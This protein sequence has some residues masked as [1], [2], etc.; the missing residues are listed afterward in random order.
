LKEQNVKLK[1]ENIKIKEEN[2]NINRLE[3]ESLELK[4]EVKEFKEKNEF[5]TNK[6]FE[7]N[8]EVKKVLVDSNIDIKEAKSELKQIFDKQVNY[9]QSVSKSSEEITK[10]TIGLLGFLQKQCPNAKPLL[11]FT[12]DNYDYEFEMNKEYIESMLYSHRNGNIGEFLGKIINNIFLKEKKED[13]SLFATDVVRYNYSI[14]EYIN[15]TKNKWIVDKGASKVVNLIIN[16]LL[17][18]IV[19]EL[20]IHL[21]KEND[22]ILK[23]GNLKS[24]DYT[25]SDEDVKLIEYKETYESNYESDNSDSSSVYRTPKNKKTSFVDYKNNLFKS[26][27]EYSDEENQDSCSEED[28]MI[29]SAAIKKQ[30]SKMNSNKN[31]KRKKYNK[32]HKDLTIKERETIIKTSTKIIEMIKD[33]ENGIITKDILK[34]ITKYYHLDKSYFD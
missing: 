26:K 9:A 11:E 20:K 30:L 25:S 7:T 23:S 16:P 17:T 31:I 21:R 28:Y 8:N 12:K 2:K 15:E 4:N 6:L 1:E 13:Q 18:Y 32:Y 29:R 10:S 5:L 34:F 33:I 19:K 27:N 3:K 22:K 14:K 24:E